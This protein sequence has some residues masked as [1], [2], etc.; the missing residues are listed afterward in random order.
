MKCHFSLCGQYLHIASLEGQLEPVSSSRRNAEKPPLKT[1]LLLS[2]YRLCGGKT[3]KSPPTLSH[4][5]KVDLGF[6]TSL[7]G[8]NLPYTLSWAPNELYFTRSADRL[9]VYRIR[10][11]NNL[12]CLD[13]HRVLTP[14][15]TV[16]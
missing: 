8:S 5:T 14:T 10:L 7:S 4:R 12:D 6:E 1:A 11:F 9:K 2:T 16:F 13:E 3:T 15:K